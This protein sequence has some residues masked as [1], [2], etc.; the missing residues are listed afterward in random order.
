MSPRALR[1]SPFWILVVATSILFSCPSIGR[2]LSSF[3]GAWEGKLEIVDATSKQDS[4]RFERTK[5]AY[6]KSLKIAIDGQRASVYFGEREIKPASFRAHI[7]M[8]NAVIFAT[9]A[10]DDSRWVETWDFALTQKNSETLI[11]AFSRVVNNLDLPEGGRDSK[12]YILAVGEFHRTS[13]GS[14]SP[15]VGRLHHLA[16][17]LGFV[18][19]MLREISDMLREIGS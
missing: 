8:T 15:E 16:P 17:V 19:D 9:D 12:F 7:Y 11:V 2:E 5:A 13:R 18:S 4:D 6:G 3:D 1:I 10:A 14:A